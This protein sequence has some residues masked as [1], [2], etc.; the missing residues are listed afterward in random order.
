MKYLILRVRDKSK[1]LSLK[2]YC[3]IVYV[4]KFL[5]IIGIQ[6]RE[7]DIKKLE[8]DPNI[9]SISENEEGT[10]QPSLALNC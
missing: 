8:N 7:Q 1:V 10:F 4:S 3:E 5:N 9:I 2:S 6:I